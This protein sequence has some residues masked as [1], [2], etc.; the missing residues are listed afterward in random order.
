MGGAIFRGVSVVAFL[1]A[2][3]LLLSGHYDP[4]I[5]TFGAVSCAIVT[6]I[7]YR[8]D[9]VDH[10]SHPIHLGWRL[11]VYLCWLLWEIVKANIDVAKRILNPRL[12]ISPT[13]FTLEAS[14]P[15][16]LGHV[17]YANSITLTPGTVTLQVNR[18]EIAVHALSQEAADDL[19]K[20]EMDRRV[21]WIEGT[22]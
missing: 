19:A 22:L 7:A 14:Q 17:I 9:V 18:D 21:T 5:L 1:V 6:L 8:M 11:P 16:E 10:E 4:L 2:T 3:W 20:G 13:V 12:P 15:T